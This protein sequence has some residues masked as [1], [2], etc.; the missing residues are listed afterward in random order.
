MMMMK[1][2]NSTT[3]RLFSEAGIGEGMRVLEL[4]CGPGEVTEVLSELVGPSGSVL[5]VDR[6]ADMLAAAEKRIRER[7][8]DN[9]QFVEA[10]L[11]APPQYLDRVAHASM[12]AI[13]GRRV[14]MYL[15]QPHEALGRLLPWLRR[16]GIV[17]FEE[18]DSTLCPGRTASMPA[19][20]QGVAWLE[21]MLAK[22]G[23]NPSMGFDLPGVLVGSGLEFRKVVAEAVIEG[24]GDQFPLAELLGL[25]QARLVGTGV[26]AASEVDELISRIGL[27]RLDPASVYVSAMRFC[28]SATKQ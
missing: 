24:Q 20:D 13:A 6:S 18:T 3:R 21:E 10:D 23:A 27:E 17:V 14:L 1:R 7:G 28:A 12:D 5:A 26:A 15:P 11:T 4:G 19:H 25:L 2:D 8:L 22:E 9:V 16:G